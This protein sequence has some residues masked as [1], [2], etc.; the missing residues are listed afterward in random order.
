MEIYKQNCTNKICRSVNPILLLNS[1]N[2]ISESFHFKNLNVLF[3]RLI[4][5]KSICLNC[6][7]KKKYFKKFNFIVRK[8]RMKL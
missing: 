8:K 5:K 4:F 1:E 6:K 2:F 7:N 3:F